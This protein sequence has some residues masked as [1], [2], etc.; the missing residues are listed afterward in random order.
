MEIEGNENK[1]KAKADD[2]DMAMEEF[3]DEIEQDPAMRKNFLLFKNDDID[4]CEI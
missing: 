3:I 4:D 1:K 2:S